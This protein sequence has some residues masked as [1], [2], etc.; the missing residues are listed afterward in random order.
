MEKGTRKV[1]PKRSNG[2]LGSMV[3]ALLASG[4][5]VAIPTLGS[6]GTAILMAL[7]VVAALALVRFRLDP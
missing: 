3:L 1:E 2:V 6:T 4:A 5:A 7:L